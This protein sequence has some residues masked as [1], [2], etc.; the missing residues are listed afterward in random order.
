MLNF[1]RRSKRGM[2]VIEVLVAMA[3]FGV[4]SVPLM[5]VF[6]DSMVATKLAQD[7]IETNALV[8][9]VKDAVTKNVKGVSGTL[10]DLSN[11]SVILNDVSGTAVTP[12]IT[13]G[14]AHD[15]KVEDKKSKDLGYKFDADRI[16]DFGQ[17]SCGGIS[18]TT[19]YPDTCEY[20]VTI[21]NIHNNVAVQKFRFYVNRVN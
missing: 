3:V 2:T 17:V 20:Q 13:T 7:K 15:L 9:I 4:I 21:K 14:S 10:N 16:Q 11:K 8:C 19:K 18:S 6:L 1:I 12:K 5:G